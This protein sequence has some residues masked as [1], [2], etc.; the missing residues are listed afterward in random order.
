MD[1]LAQRSRFEVESDFVQRSGECVLVDPPPITA[2]VGRAVIRIHLG[3]AGKIAAAGQFFAY[4][5]GHSAFGFDR[6]VRS[7]EFGPQDDHVELD[8]RLGG[9]LFEV[10]A[11]VSVDFVGRDNEV[12]PHGALPHRLHHD[13]VAFNFAEASEAE[14]L[15]FEGADKCL[16]VAAEFLTDD[17]VDAVFDHVGRNLETFGVEVIDDELAVDEV[18]QRGVL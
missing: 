16:A 4:F 15:G 18:L 7:V 12:G 14:A 2:E 3:H 17:G 9:I 8:F 13:F 11:V 1:G 10:L 6:V 5:F